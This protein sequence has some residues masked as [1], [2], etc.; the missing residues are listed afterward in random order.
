MFQKSSKQVYFN[1]LF[2]KS[3]I[4]QNSSPPNRRR[5]SEAWIAHGPWP[6]GK[7]GESHGARR[8]VAEMPGTDVRKPGSPRCCDVG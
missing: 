7:A 6:R 4:L 8:G 2:L 1:F 3:D 5:I